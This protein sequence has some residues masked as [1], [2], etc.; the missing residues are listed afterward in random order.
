M[1]KSF[2]AVAALFLAGTF[3]VQ[4]QEAP[5]IVSQP[6][7]QSVQ[8]GSSVAFTVEAVGDGPISYQW[9]FEGGEIV[10]ATDSTYSLASAAG[11][12]AGGYVVIVSN[13]FGSDTSETAVLT[14]TTAPESPTFLDFNGD[15][16][17][18]LL[19]VHPD[20][21]IA[22]WLMDGT[23]FLGSIL[24]PYTAPPG[25]RM[26]GQA[27]FDGDGKLDYLWQTT[28]NGSLR[29]WLMDGTNR[30]ETIN[31]PRRAN[32]GWKA[33]G[34]SDLNS[35]G[36]IDIIWQHGNGTVAAWL[37]NGANFSQSVLL[38]N[39]NPFRGGWKIVGVTDFDNDGQADLLWQH[40]GGRIAI[41]YMDGTNVSR[42]EVLKFSQKT[43]SS[44]RLTGH[45]DLNGD[46]EN[47]L[48]WRHSDGYVAI[49]YSN[50]TADP[51]SAP[52]RKGHR[53]NA[54]GWKLES[55]N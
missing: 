4:A 43:S 24:L 37:M 21:R 27:D 41:W 47:D 39:G 1:K 50:G 34:L 32:A 14:V 9:Y 16:K 36:S 38:N 11:S 29:L 35:D 15:G 51:V 25:S 23:N 3:G 30:L 31:F 12:D 46:G 10:G 26:V 17:P 40:G 52:I 48:L 13:E 42:S 28:G 45:S 5:V 6:P 54:G 53:V 2:I 33:V 44:W 7:S 20:G 22:A 55:R 8:V 18:D 19:W 49:W